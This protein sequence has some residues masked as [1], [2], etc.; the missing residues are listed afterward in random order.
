M[1]KRGVGIDTSILI[2]LFED[3]PTY[4]QLAED[5]L[6]SMSRSNNAIYFSMVG[7]SEIFTGIKKKGDTGLLR[8]YI[9][10]FQNFPHF[11]LVDVNFPI[12]DKAA[13]LRAFYDI[14]TP[15]ALHLATS[16]IH[17]ATTFVSNDRGLKRVKEIAVVSLEEW[18]KQQ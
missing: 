5:F 2:Y 10:F 6:R 3:H 4:A 15:D 18:K 7:V 14:R 13:D 16:I 11:T 9:A 1:G 12:A 8:K 17:H